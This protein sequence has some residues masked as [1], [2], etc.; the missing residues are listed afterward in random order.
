VVFEYPSYESAKEEVA[1]S[2]PPDTTTAGPSLHT[3]LR[4]NTSLLASSGLCKKQQK[5]YRKPSV[6]T[7]VADLDPGSGASLTLDPGFP[8]SRIR[9]TG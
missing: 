9:N 2:D 3:V 7:S 4:S 6:E 1:S 5:V 8:R